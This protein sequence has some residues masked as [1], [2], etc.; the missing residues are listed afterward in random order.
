MGIRAVL[1]W[2]LIA[3]TSTPTWAE[4]EIVTGP[5]R[6]DQIDLRIEELDAAIAAISRKGPKTATFVGLGL[7]VVGES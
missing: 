7:M 5:D 4:E 2:L 3:F 1:L 6:R